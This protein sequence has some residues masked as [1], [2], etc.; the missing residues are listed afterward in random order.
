MC[1]TAWISAGDLPGATGGAG[2]QNLVHQ[3]S[4]HRYPHSEVGGHSAEAQRTDRGQCIASCKIDLLQILRWYRWVCR[5]ADARLHELPWLKAVGAAFQRAIPPPRMTVPSGTASHD[6]IARLA[7]NRQERHPLYGEPLRPF[8]KKVGFIRA[9]AR[10]GAA[11][12]F[13]RLVRRVIASGS[14]GNVGR[15]AEPE[16]GL[17]SRRLFQPNNCRRGCSTP[18]LSS[19]NCSPR[20]GHRLG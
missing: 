4:R 10:V 17:P 7:R 13:G 14:R 12:I 11:V 8:Q 6:R 19:C 9:T 15:S 20:Y 3:V 5:P 18:S 1:C 16:E 2:N